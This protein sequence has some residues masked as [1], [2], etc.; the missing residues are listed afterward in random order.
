MNS[1]ESINRSRIGNIGDL[2]EQVCTVTT[3][4]SRV[5]TQCLSFYKNIFFKVVDPCRTYLSVHRSGSNFPLTN[6]R[7]IATLFV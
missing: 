4:L 1:L 2:Y 6:A 5:G 7:K 3:P